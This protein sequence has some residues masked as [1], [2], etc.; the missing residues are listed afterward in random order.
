M[1][2][3]LPVLD[4]LAA[5]FG[6][7]LY[8]Y[9]ETTLVAACRRVAGAARRLGLRPHY[10]LKANTS[11]ALLEIIKSES[12]AADAVSSGE[13]LAARN[14]GFAANDISFTG[15]NLGDEEL[16][17]V[18]DQ[19]V[20]PCLDSVAQLD[21]LGRLAPGSKVGLRINPRRGAGHHPHVITAGPNSK[22]GIDP[23]RLADARNTA[24][25]AGLIV[26]GLHQHVGSGILDRAIYLEL[27]HELLQIAG[28]WPE[29]LEWIDFGGG[30]GVAYEDDQAPF[31]FDAFTADFAPVLDEFRA[32][33]KIEMR[34][35][36]GRSV[37]AGLRGL[38]RRGHGH[39][40]TR[41]PSPGGLRRR[42]ESVSPAGA[43]RI[44]SSRPEPEQPR[45]KA[46]NRLRRDRQR[47]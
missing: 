9:D 16:R 34:V 27:A 31:D 41:W 29:P 25:R 6:T 40:G 18:L 39:E 44:A 45:G 47:L 20:E 38:R 15:N 23:A 8:V 10:A 4:E 7:P 42:H 13:I 26:T 35:Q 32:Q 36:P 17:T 28:S 1:S 21:R 14:A 5:R 12:L 22:F 19:G 3:E 37:V 43:V 24:E 30:F 46:A 11:R 33:R 2:L